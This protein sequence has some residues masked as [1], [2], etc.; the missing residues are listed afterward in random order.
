[1]IRDTLKKLTANCDGWRLRVAAI[2]NGTNIE[3]KM[4]GKGVVVSSNLLQ[5]TT[6]VPKSVRKTEPHSIRAARR[7][8]ER[9]V[10]VRSVFWCR[11]ALEDE[12]KP[13]E[14]EEEVKSPHGRREG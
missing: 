14:E 9:N 4:S 13:Q 7:Y 12:E 6:L 2:T 8:R 10:I 5:T 3:V 11:S 1:M